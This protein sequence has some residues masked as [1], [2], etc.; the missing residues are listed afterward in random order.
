MALRRTRAQVCRSQQEGEY[1]M[2][3][4]GRLWQVCLDHGLDPQANAPVMV[5]HAAGSGPSREPDESSSSTIPDL[6]KIEITVECT[7]APQ[8]T[9]KTPTLSPAQSNDLMLLE[10][11]C[12][13]FLLKLLEQSEP[14]VSLSTSHSGQGSGTGHCAHECAFSACQALPTQ[15]SSLAHGGNAYRSAEFQAAQTNKRWWALV[16]FS[17]CWIFSYQRVVQVLI[18]VR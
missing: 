2:R 10:S 1:A 11:V 16:V 17:T 18:L 5:S 9:Q 13:E 7:Q 12:P 4:L 8:I 15:I 3:E 6:G 14:S